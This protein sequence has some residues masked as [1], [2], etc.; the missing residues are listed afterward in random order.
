MMGGDRRGCPFRGVSSKRREE[1]SRNGMRG[2]KEGNTHP[3]IHSLNPTILNNHSYGPQKKVGKR[4]SASLSLSLLF[5]CL[6]LISPF[7]NLRSTS[8]L[9]CF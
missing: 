9:V 2:R 3:S 4:A 6:L 1:E 5:V 7:F 8:I